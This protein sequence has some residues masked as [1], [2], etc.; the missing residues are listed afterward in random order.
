MLLDRWYPILEA[1]RLGKKPVGVKRLGE[2]LTLWRDAAGT[3]V[4]FP[5]YCPH[6]GAAFAQGRVRDGEIAC[7]WHGFRFAADG[8]CTLMPSEGAEARIPDAMRVTPRPV[9][10]AHGLIWLWYGEAREHYPEIPFFPE[11]H[12][13]LRSSYESSYELPYHYSRMIETNLD[14][15]HTPFV[16][17]RYVPVGERVDPFEAGVDG[18]RIWSRG[19]LRRP[20]KAKG[21]QFRADVLLPCL[22]F[23]QLTPKIQ[24]LLSA[25][26]VDEN[27]TW[28]W[29][30]YQQSYTRLPLLRRLFAWFPVASELWLVQPQDWRIFEAMAP[31]TIDEVPHRYTRADQAI[32]LYRKTRH[33]L[34]EAQRRARAS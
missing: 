13:D 6:R 24:I 21:M 32:G 19:T 4:A 17:G 26:P 14:V 33:A 2:P 22:G 5:S 23:L 15:A 7:P 20:D 34:L 8:R 18:D 28:L 10:E 29:F 16:H 25:T 31:G 12:P 11:A 3:P 9:R 1:R 30:R 27:T